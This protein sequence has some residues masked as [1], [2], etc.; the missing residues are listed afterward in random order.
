MTLIEIQ[1]EDG[2]IMKV[3]EKIIKF[4]EL[5]N[6]L[7]EN[8]DTKGCKPLT[9]ITENDMNL[10]IEFCEACDYTEIK[11]NTPLWKQPFHIHYD[12][13]I[14]GKEKLEKFY[15]ELT[16]E[17]LMKYIKISYFYESNPLK[18]F[19]YFKLYDVFNDEKKCKEYFKDKDKEIMETILK[20]NDE[21]MNHLY[22]KYNDFIERQVNTLSPE[23][24]DNCL[25]QQ[26]P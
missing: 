13:I 18:E 10:L 16:C 22:N 7:N 23:D 2:K 9:G 20:F 24:I 19:M 4:S 8:Y 3:D 26:F 17:K 11:F 1:T 12:E 21:K 25:L 6:T 14:K 15:K 5:F